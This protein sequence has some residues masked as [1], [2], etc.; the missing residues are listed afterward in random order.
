MICHNLQDEKR[1]RRAENGLSFSRSSTVPV[2]RPPK[3]SG[4]SCTEKKVNRGKQ[5]PSVA[6]VDEDSRG[7]APFVYRRGQA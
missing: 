2:L 1:G 7:V 3:S 5:K 4:S 6:S